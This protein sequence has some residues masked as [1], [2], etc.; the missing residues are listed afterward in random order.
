MDNLFDFKKGY[1][2]ARKTA[3][4]SIRVEPEVYRWIKSQNLSPTRIFD[5]A[6]F[7]L[8]RKKGFL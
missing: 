7:N 1:V 8:K 6:V 3:S 5:I 4:I 2:R